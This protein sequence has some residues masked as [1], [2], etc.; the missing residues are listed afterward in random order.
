MGRP[1]EG[2]LVV[3]VEQA[4]AAPLCSCRLADAGA[5]VIKAEVN[6]RAQFTRPG[7]AP[8]VRDEAPDSGGEAGVDFPING[9]VALVTDDEGA[10]WRELWRIDG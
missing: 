5:R 6:P 8:H 3:S 10:T 4:V 1:L 2:M 7:D 9:V